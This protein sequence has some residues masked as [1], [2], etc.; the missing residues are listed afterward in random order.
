MSHTPVFRPSAVL[1]DLQNK[2]KYMSRQKGMLEEEIEIDKQIKA[3][4]KK[5]MEKQ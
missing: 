2:K 5:E 3:I 4:T 1:L